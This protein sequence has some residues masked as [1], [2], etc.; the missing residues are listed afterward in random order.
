MRVSPV[1]L[2]GLSVA[3]LG[4]ALAVAAPA[5]ASPSYLSCESWYNTIECSANGPASSTSW[6]VNGSHWT[7][8]DNKFVLHFSCGRGTYSI[9]FTK[10]EAGVT[11][12]EGRSVGCSSLP[13]R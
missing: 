13:P 7:A 1:A 8:F 3:T 2:V 4:A 11:T 12:T 10:T 9:K 6:T 5:Q